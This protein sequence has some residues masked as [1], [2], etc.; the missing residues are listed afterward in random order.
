MACNTKHGPAAA[1]RVYEEATGIRLTQKDWHLIREEARLDSGGKLSRE[2]ISPEEAMTVASDFYDAAMKAGGKPV[3]PIARDKF[4]QE[5]ASQKNTAGTLHTIDQVTE[6]GLPAAVT[7]RPR[8][9]GKAGNAKE[10]QPEGDG[11]I[12]QNM[13]ANGVLSYSSDTILGAGGVGA[14]E[15]QNAFAVMSNVANDTS[16]AGDYTPEEGVKAAVTMGA[17]AAEI[18]ESSDLIG[19]DLAQVLRDNDIHSIHDAVTG[20]TLTPRSG[21]RYRGWNHEGVQSELTSQI[22]SANNMEP[23]KVAG[24]IGAYT[25]FASVDGYRPSALRERGLRAKDFA[26]GVAGQRSVVVSFGGERPSEGNWGNVQAVEANASDMKEVATYIANSR[27]RIKTL[28]IDD[29][30]RE[31][32]AVRHIERT[33][34]R[35]AQGIESS[36]SKKLT[37][38]DLDEVAGYKPRTTAGGEKWDSDDLERK[39]IP[40]VAS[41]ASVTEREALTV[42]SDFKS[43]A[44][45]RRYKVR[46]LKAVDIDAD[47]YRTKTPGSFKLAKTEEGAA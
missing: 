15:T 2:V 22:A 37:D 39:I 12:T 40:L 29:A 8:R 38:S 41:S 18:K 30:V 20:T 43:V 17:I 27:E 35:I 16:L 24:V 23:E 45:V 6:H 44:E 32:V 33:A 28:P 47:E 14:P 4:V 34:T 7:E 19:E 26:E 3:D 21:Y 46:G 9:S 13:S 31:Y 10:G 42:I 1:I 36:V 25:E 11:N 5:F